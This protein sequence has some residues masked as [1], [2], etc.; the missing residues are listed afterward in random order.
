[1][2][3]DTYV[4]LKSEIGTSDL[5]IYKVYRDYTDLVILTNIAT[6]KTK[7]VNACDLVSIA[8]GFELLIQLLVDDGKKLDSILDK[9]RKEV[10]EQ[11][12]KTLLMEE[13]LKKQE[14][15]AE[16][17]LYVAFKNVLTAHLVFSINPDEFIRIWGNS[18]NEP[19]KCQRI[20]N[21]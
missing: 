16:Q 19:I 12:E 10:K 21:E 13:E 8:E 7:A 6:G 11:R 15:I 5:A 3:K 2:N 14:D 20:N 17:T 9:M 18:Y 1:M 4:F